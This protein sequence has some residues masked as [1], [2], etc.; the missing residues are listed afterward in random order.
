MSFFDSI[1]DIT[2]PIVPEPPTRHEDLS[3]KPAS[4]IAY[5]NAYFSGYGP[6]RR[7]KSIYER[8]E[9]AYR[10]LYYRL[11]LEVDGPID[12][13]RKT[14]TENDSNEAIIF[15]TSDHGDLLGAHGGLHQ[16]WFT[17]YD[18]ATRVPFQIVKTGNQPTSSK[19]ISNIPTSHIDLIPTALG[20]AGLNQEDLSEKL[21]PS[22]TEMH[23]LPG[24]DLSPLLENH[25][26]NLFIVNFRNKLCNN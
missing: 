17:L 13:V 25:N 19:I 8:N 11:H 22:F 1:D 9:Q 21:S 7:V 4:Q 5:K 23:P 2:S 12:S 14:V 18:E 15:R 10:D 20:L 24:R 16:K 6:Y 3:S 26:E